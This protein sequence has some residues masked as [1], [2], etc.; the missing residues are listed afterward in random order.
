MD[1]KPKIRPYSGNSAPDGGARHINLV[2]I[3]SQLTAHAA[4][5]ALH[6]IVLLSNMHGWNVADITISSIQLLVVSV[7]TYSHRLKNPGGQA[8]TYMYVLFAIRLALS[9]VVLICIVTFAVLKGK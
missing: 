2:T 7:L 5:V 4:L 1:G 6:L 3:Y 8:R 9:V